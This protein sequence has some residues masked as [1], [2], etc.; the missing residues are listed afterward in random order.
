MTTSF[1]KKRLADL[2]KGR[3]KE[4][5]GLVLKNAHPVTL[6]A[7]VL[8]ENFRNVQIKTLRNMPEALSTTVDDSV[9]SE[10]KH[11]RSIDQTEAHFPSSRLAE[12][13]F[14]HAHQPLAQGQYGFTGHLL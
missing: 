5:M 11:G 7:T 10:R 14:H 4:A 13:A 1:Q 6:R 2:P 3:P 12:T 8:A 9:I